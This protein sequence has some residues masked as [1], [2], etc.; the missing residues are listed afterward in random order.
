MTEGYIQHQKKQAEKIIQATEEL[1]LKGGVDSF[2]MGNIADTAG[3]TRA[4]V[5][6]YFT[7]KEDILWAI[8]FGKM[9]E[10]LTRV[11]EKF[12][13]SK[14]TLDRLH[15]YAEANYEYYLEDKTFAIFFDLFLT[16]FSTA[17]EKPKS[18]WDNPYNVAH[19]QPGKTI[20]MFNENFDDGSVRAGLD[21]KT[22]VPAFYYAFLGTISFD[23][24]N[25][26]DLE[27]IY[28]LD[29]KEVLQMQVDW[30]LSGIKS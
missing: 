1:Y 13:K 5:Y 2:T 20:A 9:A 27:K 14:T 11:E 8:F 28:K 16:I 21:A 15:A 10:L 24:K 19:W 4:T 29:L 18:F 23:F 26:K 6:N 12:K 25:R 22:T 17:S 3:I 30:I 7:C